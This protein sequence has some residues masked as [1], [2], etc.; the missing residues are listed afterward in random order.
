M[1]FVQ[2]K[3]TGNDLGMFW[4]VKASVYCEEHW[5]GITKANSNWLTSDTKEEQNRGG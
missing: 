5:M 4:K 3:E 2:I 1:V